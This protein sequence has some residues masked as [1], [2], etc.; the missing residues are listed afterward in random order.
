MIQ[1]TTT[2]QSVPESSNS[3]QYWDASHVIHDEENQL[4][5]VR[6]NLWTRER[7]DVET[8]S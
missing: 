6:L 2:N 7:Q 3:K 4:D 1:Q 5:G 8:S